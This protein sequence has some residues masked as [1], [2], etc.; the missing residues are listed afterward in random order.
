MS[1]DSLS[2]I[3][4][5]LLLRYSSVPFARRQTCVSLSTFTP[6]VLKR[7]T[8]ITISR[9]HIGKAILSGLTFFLATPV[10]VTGQDSK[11]APVPAPNPKPPPAP[12]LLRMKKSHGRRGKLLPTKC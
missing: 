10:L 6:P 8:E 12:K 11:P 3:I 4:Q 7:S 1:H 5:E 9:M 2:D